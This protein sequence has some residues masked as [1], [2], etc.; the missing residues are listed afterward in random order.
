M[1]KVFSLKYPWLSCQVGTDEFF[2]FYIGCFS[3]WRG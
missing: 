2:L 3:I 1:V